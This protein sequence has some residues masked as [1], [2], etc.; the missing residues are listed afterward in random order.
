MT[1]HDGDGDEATHKADVKNQT[2]HRQESDACKTAGQDSRCD[3]VENGSTRDT[4]NS[5]LPSCDTKIVVSERCEVVTVDAE[6]N[7]STAKCQ[8]IEQ[9]LEKTKGTAF[10]ETHID[11]VGN[12]VKKL[13]QS[14]A[15]EV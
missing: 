4:L 2:E 12:V 14:P 11:E 6:D 9:R 1:G 13:D 8:S 5:L 3:G 10:E 7:A 15:V